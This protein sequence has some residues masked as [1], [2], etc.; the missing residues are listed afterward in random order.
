M[1]ASHYRC[2][3]KAVLNTLKKAVRD[4]KIIDTPTDVLGAGG[5]HIA[6][7]RI[8]DLL[9]IER[10]ECVVETSFVKIVFFG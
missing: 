2:E 5:K 6:P 7:P 3:D 8:F 1:V 9:G 4:H 10:A